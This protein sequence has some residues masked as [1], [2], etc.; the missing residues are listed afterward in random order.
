MHTSCLLNMFLD[1]RIP[2]L[3]WFANDP[4]TTAWFAWNAFKYPAT[5]HVRL[6]MIRTGP[7][8]PIPA[9]SISVDEIAVKTQREPADVPIR[10]FYIVFLDFWQYYFRL[11][12]YLICFDI[13]V[14]ATDFDSSKHKEVHS[15]G[16]LWTPQ[17]RLRRHG[18][19]DMCW[20]ILVFEPSIT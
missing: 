5:G 7:W 20:L 1:V 13:V 15:G 14:P 9:C 16:N 3:E 19:H 12:W 2:E 10:V 6:D 17:T 8:K 4:T 18:H 11:L